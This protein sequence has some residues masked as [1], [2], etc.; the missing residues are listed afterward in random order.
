MEMLRSRRLVAALAQQ[1]SRYSVAVLFL[2]AALGGCS[3]VRR[4]TGLGAAP[5]A[6]GTSSGPPPAFV[7]S[8]VDSRITRVIDVR[9]GLAKPAAFKAAS[10]LVTQKFTIDVSDAHAGFLMTPWQ[11]SFSHDGVPDLR[12]RT[13]VI[14]RFV[15]EDWKQVSV[16]AEANW[17]RGEDWEVGY[18]ASLL[19]QVTADL[20]ARIGKKA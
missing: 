6:G 13:R 17:Q 20:R 18:D 4:R 11:A 2:A 19:D 3:A 1:T 9:E 14:I 7:Q 8:T 16:K 10:D 5:A 15:G 12:Y